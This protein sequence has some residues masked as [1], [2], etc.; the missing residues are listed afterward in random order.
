MKKK[1]LF[2]LLITLM[3]MVFTGCEKNTGIGEITTYSTEMGQAYGVVDFSEETPEISISNIR[4]LVGEEIDYSSGIKIENLGEEVD[5]QLWIDASK[6]DIYEK[7]DYTAVYKFVYG[8]ETIEKSIYV[9]VVEEEVE[10]VVTKENTSSSLKTETV[11]DESD[12][13]Q[14]ETENSVSNNTT[15][16]AAV[17]E[18]ANDPTTKSGSE[19]VTA[20]KQ[21]T[22]TTTKTTVKE[23]T[24]KKQII[25]SAANNITTK[26][27]NI[28]Y[29]NI[30]LL[31]GSVVK[32]KCTTSKY[33][34]STRTDVS[35]VTKNGTKY[36]VSKLI[37]TFNTGAE[38]VLETNEEKLK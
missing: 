23:T 31:S 10:G 4:S 8:E 19:S 21:T 34:V 17:T 7:G 24:S 18:V 27:K 28:G 35:T 11:A 14:S 25:T 16:T 1:V 15:K 20:E 13:Q 36:R 38:Q 26:I 12:P 5:F 2:S 3:V 29:M 9:S 22:K 6:V 33:I 32:I 37:V 30:E